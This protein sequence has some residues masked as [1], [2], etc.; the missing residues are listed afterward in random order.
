MHCTKSCFDALHKISSDSICKR[1]REGNGDDDDYDDY[2]EHDFDDDDDDN[3]HK[4]F[5]PEGN[6]IKIISQR[7]ERKQEKQKSLGSPAA[8]ENQ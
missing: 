3:L 2:D 5:T 6:L 7:K 8:S 4:V 1:G